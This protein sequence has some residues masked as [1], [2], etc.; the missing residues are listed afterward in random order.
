MYG[1]RYLVVV[2]LREW[3]AFRTASS[4]KFNYFNKTYYSTARVVG[5]RKNEMLDDKEIIK[6]LR[7][8]IVELE[9]ELKNA[10]LTQTPQAIKTEAL[11]KEQLRQCRD[12][13]T[14]YVDGTIDDPVDSGS[15]FN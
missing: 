6:R 12:L 1:S 14:G 7:K 3:R 2:L 11:T 4:K 8:R 13:M 15:L 10:T 5:C 9:K